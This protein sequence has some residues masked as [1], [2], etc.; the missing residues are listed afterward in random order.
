MAVHILKRV[1]GI[2]LVVDVAK[3]L[4]RWVERVSTGNRYGARCKALGVFPTV[5]ERAAIVFY[6]FLTTLRAPVVVFSV[7]LAQTETESL[8]PNASCSALMRLRAVEPGAPN[9]SPSRIYRSR[10]IAVSTHGALNALARKRVLHTIERVG[11]HVDFVRF[12][13]TTY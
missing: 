9:Y 6:R 10:L 13:R 8:L 4:V 7:G 12:A 5:N 1:L 2:R 11:I 3:R